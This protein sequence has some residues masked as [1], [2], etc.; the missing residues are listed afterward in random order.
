MH[1]LK[2]ENDALL[3]GL[4]EDLNLGGSLSESSEGWLQRGKG[5]SQDI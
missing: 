5:G 2:V 4:S 3:G 1:N